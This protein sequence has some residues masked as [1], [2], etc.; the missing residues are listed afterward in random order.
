[1]HRTPRGFNESFGGPQVRARP[2]TSARA[3]GETRRIKSDLF[4]IRT[5]RHGAG[6]TNRDERAEMTDNEPLLWQIRLES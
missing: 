2:E 4:L 3:A 6:I 1:M 5:Q